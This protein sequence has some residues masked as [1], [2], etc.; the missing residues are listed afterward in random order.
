MKRFLSSFFI[1]F[2]W[3]S[4]F[5]EAE[6]LKVPLRELVSV[7]VIDLKCSS[8]EYS[9]KIPLAKRWELK[10]TILRFSYVNSSALLYQNSR[11]LIKLNGYPLAQIKLNPTAPEGNAEILLP[12]NL[13]REGYND[14]T[15]KVTQHYTTDCEDF[16]APELWTTL[17]LDEATLEMDY[18]LKNIPLRL[19]SIGEYLFEPKIYPEPRVNIICEK[20][21][22]EFLSAVGVIASGISFKFDY[23]K[24][25]FHCNDE[26]QEGCDNVLVGSKKFVEDFLHKKGFNI[27]PRGPFLKIM[28][29][30]T[31]SNPKGDSSYALIIV[32]GEDKEQLKLAAETFSVL[33]FSD[34]TD[35]ELVGLEVPRTY[36]YSGKLILEPGKKHEFRNLNFKT[37]TLRGMYPGTVDIPLRLSTDLLIKPNLYTDIYLHFIYGAGMRR[38]SVLNIILNGKHIAGIALSDEKGGVYS[39]YKVSIPTYLFKRGINTLTF[40]PILTPLIAKSCEYIQTENLFLTLFEDSKIYFPEMPHLVDMPRIELLFQDGF[41]FTRWPDG[42]ETVIS[43]AKNDLHTLAAALNLIGLL[44]QKVGYP[45]FRIRITTKV[46]EFPDQEIILIGTVEKLPLRVKKLTPLKLTIPSVVPY[47]VLYRLIGEPQTGW[48]VRFK[49]DFLSL[50]HSKLVLPTV[51]DFA[52][53]TQKISCLG[54]KRVALMLFQSPSTKGRSVLLLTANNSEEIEKFSQLLLDPSL[55]CECY[56]DLVMADL[57]SVPYKLTSMEIGPRYYS[58]K[59]GVLSPRYQSLFIKPWYFLLILFLTILLLGTGA[60][61]LLKRHMIKRVKHE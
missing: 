48:W 55:Q 60:Y 50:F 33:N 9:V 32:S 7:G 18:N 10:K 22:D 43:L 57:D 30:P 37:T 46:V 40:E 45:L 39:A 28:H 51:I 27:K 21:S 26:I 24:V 6:L 58:I 31:K 49:K 47:P 5:A 38:D 14:L 54:A 15:F 25:F 23:R 4:S 56:G 59:K 2:F 20:D 41:P 16:C 1:F 61:I 35:L 12:A 29:L 52:L 8:A 53:S 3:V 42:R 19:S 36:S 44:T 34:V 17:K 13:L 11:L